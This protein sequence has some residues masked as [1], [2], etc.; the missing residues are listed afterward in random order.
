VPIAMCAETV[1]SLCRLA[2]LRRRAGA[3]L[4]QGSAQC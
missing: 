1:V 4:Q 2:I 3:G